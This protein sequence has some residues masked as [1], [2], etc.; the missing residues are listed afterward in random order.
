MPFAHGEWLA[1]HVPGARRHLYDDEGHLTLVA[2]LTGSSAT[3]W[4]WPG[5]AG[6][7]TRLGMNSSSTPSASVSTRIPTN[8]RC[9][10]MARVAAVG[11]SPTTPLTSAPNT[12]T[13]I[14]E[15]TERENMLVAVATPRCPQATLVCATTRAGAAT[16]PIP[17]PISRQPSGDVPER[18]RRVHQRQ[19]QRTGDGERDAEQRRSSGTRGEVEP[20]GRA[21]PATGQPSVRAASAKPLTMAEAPMTSWPSVGT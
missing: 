6:G 8:T 1:D 17:N 7:V 5:H 12:A 18:A 21:P 15:P 3:C 19:H 2:R 4:T 10:P 13:P 16:E 20:A 11:W 14:A 9:T